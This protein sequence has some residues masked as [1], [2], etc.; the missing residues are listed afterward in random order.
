MIIKIYVLKSSDLVLQKDLPVCRNEL[1]HIDNT[2]MFF[3]LFLTVII[4]I[5][6]S[7]PLTHT[8]SHTEWN[9]KLPIDIITIH[10]SDTYNEL[11][12]ERSGGCTQQPRP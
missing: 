7:S 4:I 5:I 1:H 12:A 9:T 10:L 11:Q 3:Y 2:N 8:R 6:S